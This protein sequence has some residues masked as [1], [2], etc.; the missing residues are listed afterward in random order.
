M[1]PQANLAKAPRRIKANFYGLKAVETSA[2][3]VWTLVP[4]AIES[5]A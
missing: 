2:R 1:L 5:L 3:S 4:S